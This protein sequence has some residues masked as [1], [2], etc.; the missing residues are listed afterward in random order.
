MKRVILASASP[1]RQEILQG[2]GIEFEVIPSRE[3]EVI[4]GNEPKEIVEELAKRKAAC[5]ARD[6]Q[7]DAII[8]GAD[9]IVVYEGVIL[10]KPGDVG[11]AKEMLFKLQG[12]THEVYTGVAVIQK[13]RNQKKLLSFW[14][15]TEVTFYPM[16][17]KEIDEYVATKEPMDKAGAYG[18]QGRGCVY[19]KEISGDYWN[20]V[21]LPVS[22]LLHETENAGIQLRS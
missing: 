19:V 17:E 3:E 12:K 10:G 9:T 4:T 5:V 8:I 11:Q 1:R 16:K 6:I 20:V 2:A 22:R 18:I 21:G 14:Q 7:E 13:E 15:K